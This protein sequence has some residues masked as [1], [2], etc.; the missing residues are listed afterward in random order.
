M[1]FHM[2]RGNLS[3]FISDKHYMLIG[4]ILFGFALLLLII[5]VQGRYKCI[6]YPIMSIL[7]AE[8]LTKI[9]TFFNLMFHT[10]KQRKK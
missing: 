5:E 9:L 2:G 3:F 4:L 8:G 10:I 7:A 1:P 6:M